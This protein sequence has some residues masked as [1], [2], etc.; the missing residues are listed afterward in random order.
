MNPYLLIGIR[1]SRLIQLLKR[2]KVG[3]KPVQLAKI[4][5]LLFNSLWS[6]FL[7]R[8]EKIKYGDQIAK[9]ELPS[10]ILIIIGHWRTG[11][12]YLHNLLSKDEN[13]A[14]P[15]LY[16]T[17][18]PDSFLLS[19][20]YIKPVMSNF[21]EKHRPMDKV[22]LGVDL[23]QEDEYAL[24]KMSAHTPLE[25]MIFPNGSAYFLQPDNLENTGKWQDALSVFCRKLNVKFNKN[26]LLKNPFHSFRIKELAKMFPQA[27]FIC[28]HRHPYAVVPSTMK[29]WSHVGKDNNLSGTYIPPEISEVTDI[30]SKMYQKIAVDLA[31]LPSDKYYHIKYEDLETNPVGSI[32]KM[33]EK[34]GY[35]FGELLEKS[36][37]K[38]IHS[39]GDYPKNEFNLS[40][41]QK[42]IIS[43]SLKDYMLDYC[44]FS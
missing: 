30:F 34:L 12:T 11:S 3:L 9:A 37:Q 33:Y 39:L 42:Q 25:R 24:V 22:E 29:L 38:Y 21:V 5:F 17:V 7:A 28:I 6:S 26:I 20:K 18:L 36:L 31:M 41:A 40:E 14:T 10:E 13:F 44:Y 35:P 16:H 23:P 8:V 4:L 43:T 32:K 27:K 19:E 2:N 1:F 15:S